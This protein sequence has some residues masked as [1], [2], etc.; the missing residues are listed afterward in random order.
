G[1]SVDADQLQ[2]LEQL[3]NRLAPG[4]RILVT[5]YPV[6]LA[7]GKRE[8]RHHGLRNVSDLVKVAAQGGVCLWLHGHRHGPYFLAKPNLAPFPVICAG[9]ATQ[10]GLWTFNE[11]EVDGRYFRAMRR[12]F[13]LDNR[14]FREAESFEL[15]LP[16]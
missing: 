15:Q 6:C 1:G 2:R 10:S 8:R 12:S 14:R 9:S 5:H 16:A 3:L 4:L 7:S 13:D 11:Y